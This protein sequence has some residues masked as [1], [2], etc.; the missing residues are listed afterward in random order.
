M[1][2]LNK[3]VKVKDFLDKEDKY[4]VAMRILHKTIVDVVS[5]A[6]YYDGKDYYVLKNRWLYDDEFSKMR[7]PRF[8]STG[9]QKWSDCEFLVLDKGVKSILSEICVHNKGYLYTSHLGGYLGK[10]IIITDSFCQNEG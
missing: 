2:K 1:I 7:N 10:N 4:E 3:D 9:V 5:I 8:K 6:L